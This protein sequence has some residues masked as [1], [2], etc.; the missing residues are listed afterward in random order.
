MEPTIEIDVTVVT[1]GRVD[2]DAVDYARRKI[3]KTLRHGATPARR[4]VVHLTHEP[5]PARDRPF[6]AE[7]TID[8]DG[9][10][11]RA[12]VGGDAM[13]EAIDLLDDRLRRRIDES[14]SRKRALIMRHRDDG[15]G[16]WRHGSVPAERPQHFVR[17]VDEREIIRH[18]SFTV[19]QQTIDEAVFD[20][21]TLDHDF[22]L[23][24]DERTGADAVVWRLDGHYALIESDGSA[25]A[26]DTVAEVE[27]RPIPVPTISVEA[28]EEI[29]DG[30]DVPFVFFVNEETG[31]GNVVYWRYDGHYG[32]IEPAG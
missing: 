8:R 17:P 1:K 4:A 24:R 7:A 18:K 9:E 21:E 23:F 14:E 25:P 15:P 5:D 19:A 22:F 29:L 2:A 32:L 30:E 3:D 13:L 26:P 11:I 20:L 12:H 27:V 28:A 10:A 16:E 31:R 6:I